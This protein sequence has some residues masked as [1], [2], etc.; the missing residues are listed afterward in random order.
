MPLNTGIISGAWNCLNPFKKDKNILERWAGRAAWIAAFTAAAAVVWKFGQW[1]FTDPMN[2]KLIHM[3]AKLFKLN[4]NLPPEAQ[5]K[6]SAQLKEIHFSRNPHQFAD[7][8]EF[9]HT[10]FAYPWGI[11]K[12]PQRSIDLV[13]KALNANIFG[14]KEPKEHILDV[15]FSYH[16]GFI[17]NFPPICLAGPPGVGK[18][19]FATTLATALGLPQLIISAAGMDDPDSFFRG[20]SRTYKGSVPGFFVTMFTTC[21]CINPVIVIDE[22]DKEAKGNSKGTIQNILLQILDPAQNT[23]FRDKYLDLPI[24]VSQPFYILTANNLNN[25]IEPLQDRMIVINI[26]NY[27]PEELKE[28]AYGIVWN[29]ILGTK[30]I[31]AATKAEIIEKTLQKLP[32]DT[33]VRS[34]KKVLASSVIRWLRLH[35]KKAPKTW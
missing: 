16:Q 8:E 33:S 11:T 1:F 13:Q 31:P 19:V 27:S 23:E 12:E 18:T 30:R 24:D 4:K 21:G 10:V 2:L 28:M 34:V 22:I 26:P 17:S 25:V 15:L 20:F 32:K 14:M 35:Y 3:Q 29:A 6:L 9:A 5:K 7:F